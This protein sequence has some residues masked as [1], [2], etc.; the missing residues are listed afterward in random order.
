MKI[1]GHEDEKAAGRRLY[2]RVYLDGC[3]SGLGRRPHSTL[4]P[5]QDGAQES[6]SAARWEQLPSPVPRS[7]P[8]SP[9]PIPK[10]QDD[11]FLHG[12]TTGGII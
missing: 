2:W 8:D 9:L 3:L 1:P 11:Q 6:T 10:E 4:L 12:L 5:Y 7:P